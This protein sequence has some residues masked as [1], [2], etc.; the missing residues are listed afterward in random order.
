MTK[1]ER[2]SLWLIALRQ[3]LCLSQE[4]LAQD[5]NVSFCSINRWENGKSYPFRHMFATIENYIK[6]KIKDKH[7]SQNDLTAF[8]Q[9]TTESKNG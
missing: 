5:L 2:L 7:L 1:N 8:H 6:S 4:R 9:A 3:K